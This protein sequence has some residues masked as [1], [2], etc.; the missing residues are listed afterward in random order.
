MYIFLKGF[1]GLIL[2]LE[3]GKIYHFSFETALTL[4]VQNMIA[5][6]LCLRVDQQKEKLS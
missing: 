1:A 6:A 3:M 5:L 4:V 2:I